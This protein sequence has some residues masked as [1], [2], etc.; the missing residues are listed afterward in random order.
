MFCYYIL[1][2]IMLY[3]SIIYIYYLFIIYPP[4]LGSSLTIVTLSV[5]PS[6]GSKIVNAGDMTCCSEKRKSKKSACSPSPSQS[7]HTKSC[8][9]P[10]PSQNPSRPSQIFSDPLRNQHALVNNESFDLHSRLRGRQEQFHLVAFLFSGPPRTST[11]N[12][13]LRSQRDPTLLTCKKSDTLRLLRFLQ[14]LRSSWSACGNVGA[15]DVVATM[16][17]PCRPLRGKDGSV[18]DGGDSCVDGN[19]DGSD[20]GGFGRFTAVTVR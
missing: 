2:C 12:R 5:L 14:V 11:G 7:W 8:S 18:C 19:A 9:F 10:P 6:D 3:Y 16:L 20:D 15:V 17:K 4:F 13:S 1:Y